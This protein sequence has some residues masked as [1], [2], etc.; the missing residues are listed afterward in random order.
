MCWKDFN[1]RACEVVSIP[2]WN[3]L[4]AFVS[5]MERR[6][7]GNGCVLEARFVFILMAN[8]C[9]GHRKN[10]HEILMTCTNNWHTTYHAVI[11]A[12]SEHKYTKQ[13]YVIELL[14]EYVWKPL[15]IH[16]YTWSDLDNEINN[17]QLQ[18]TSRKSQWSCSTS[19][20]SGIQGPKYVAIED[21]VGN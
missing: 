10:W 5:L 16:H 14:E 2:N 17:K 8:A 21:R 11:M 18:T 19:Q 6:A 12:P 1:C 7:V 13:R 9:M 20:V 15:C 4:S 3:T